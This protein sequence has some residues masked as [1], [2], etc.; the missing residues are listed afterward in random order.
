MFCRRLLLSRETARLAN[1]A[2]E[3]GG[4]AQRVS[5]EARVPRGPAAANG[6]ELQG[7]EGALRKRPA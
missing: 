3:A 5:Y 2:N 6:S 1:D 4:T 7:G